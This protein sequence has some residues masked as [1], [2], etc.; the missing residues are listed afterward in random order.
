MFILWS[1]KGQLLLMAMISALGWEVAIKGQLLVLVWIGV[2]VG[3]SAA[4]SNL[5]LALA[6]PATWTRFGR[7]RRPAG[8]SDLEQS[9][10]LSNTLAP[11]PLLYSSES[12]F[13]K[14]P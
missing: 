1:I 9:S 2:G 4:T 13:L 5:P 10:P 7:H 3:V 8:G 6:L 11:E 12:H 14:H